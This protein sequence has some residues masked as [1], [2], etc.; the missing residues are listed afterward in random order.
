MHLA[1]QQQGPKAAVPRIVDHAERRASIARSAALAI[2]ELG[3]EQATMREIAARSGVSKGIVEHYFANRDEVIETALEWANARYVAR[4]TRHTRGLQGMDALRERLRCVLPLDAE[5]RQD[6]KIRL[7][8]WSVAAVNAGARKAQRARLDRTR[9]RFVTDLQAARALGQA[10]A[11][12]D[13]VATA[14]ELM[15]L[16][17]GLACDALL[18]PRYYD[19][20]YLLGLIDTTI[21]RLTGRSQP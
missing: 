21:N 2:A 14:N 19:R 20:P 3:L 1:E 18:D 6:W 16:V 5:S 4:E 7:C 8:V 11:G 12:I 15:H 17:A 13:P 9:E 10:P